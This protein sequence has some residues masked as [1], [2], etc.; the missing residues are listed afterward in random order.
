[1]KHILNV[2]DHSRFDKELRVS[3]NK[4]HITRENYWNSRFVL[5][6]IPE[7]NSLDDPHLRIHLAVTSQKKFLNPAKIKR[8]FSNL[9]LPIQ[10]KKPKSAALKTLIMDYKKIS[11]S[12]DIDSKFVEYFLLCLDNLDISE[13]IK[14]LITEIKKISSGTSKMQIA[15]NSI[16]EREILISEIKHFIIFNNISIQTIETYFIEALIKLRNLSIS[17]VIKIL[18]WKEYLNWINPLS[19][20]L[21]N[22]GFIWKGE[23]YLIKLNSD[24]YFLKQSKLSEFFNF[25]HKNDPFL[26]YPSTLNLNA[27]ANKFIIPIPNNQL[28]QLRYCEIKL[29][30]ESVISTSSLLKA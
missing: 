9:F 5:A 13:K 14:I 7:Y 20:K 2:Q 29:L 28:Q 12:N 15:Y 21:L 3:S 25:S 4:S 16:N 6:K 1:M 10:N 30:E 11:T 18:E 22:I 27:A 17:V 8:P 26:I 23:N 24:L 19:S